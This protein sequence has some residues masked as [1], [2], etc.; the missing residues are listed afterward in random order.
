MSPQ[1]IA[2]LG[3]ERYEKPINSQLEHTFET[4]SRTSQ[5]NFF[6]FPRPE[7]VDSD[8]EVESGD[9]SQ[10]D[11]VDSKS[12][13]SS[14]D[15]EPL[16]VPQSEVITYVIF[17]QLLVFMPL[18]LIGLPW[19]LI[20]SLHRLSKAKIELPRT[21]AAVLRLLRQL[22][23]GTRLWALL[24]IALFSVIKKLKRG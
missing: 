14:H 17:S 11:P 3:L 4:G 1:A 13:N 15:Q 10:S 2:R 9:P 19:F 8:P 24:F 23:T 7:D 22:C 20:I 12:R 5:V 6:L 21:R 16:K 18:S